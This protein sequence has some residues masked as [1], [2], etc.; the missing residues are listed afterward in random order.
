[1]R[2]WRSTAARCDYFGSLHLHG[3]AVA[4]RSVGG[5][6]VTR[7]FGTPGDA[8]SRLI[9]ELTQRLSVKQ[10]ALT[11]DCALYYKT[12]FG[13][14]PSPPAPDSLETAAAAKIPSNVLPLKEYFDNRGKIR[15]QTTLHGLMRDEV[16]N[17]VD[18]RRSYLDIFRAVRS[19]QLA[20]GSWYY[21][22]VLLADVVHLLDAAVVSGCLT[23]QPR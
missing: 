11:G 5:A 7:V 21:G 1:M 19:E 2:R 17:F 16:F 6:D 4:I 9:D 18:G 23:L 12:L 20:A 8:G 13:A 3:K 10:T 15:V 22:T 14:E